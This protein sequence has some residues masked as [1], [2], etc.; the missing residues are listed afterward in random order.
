MSPH[1]EKG[2]GRGHLSDLLTTNS[3]EAR[4][5]NNGKKNGEKAPA[6]VRTDEAAHGGRPGTERRI[7]NRGINNLK[8]RNY[9]KECNSGNSNGSDDD[10][11][12]M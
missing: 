10:C 8:L 11:R 9:E 12:I 6:T 1:K 7:T 2:K 5:R 4:K 3:M